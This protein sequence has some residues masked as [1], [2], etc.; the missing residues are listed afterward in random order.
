MSPR[1]LDTDRCPHCRADL[2][3]PVPRSCPECGGSLQKRYL[4][5]GCLTS[6]PMLVL[7]AAGIAWSVARAL[8][9]A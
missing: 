7:L 1:I 8:E 3:E 4:E 2:P 6:K 5:S 9:F